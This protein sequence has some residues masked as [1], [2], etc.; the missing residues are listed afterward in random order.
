[1]TNLVIGAVAFLISILIFFVAIEVLEDQRKADELEE[2]KKQSA[3]KRAE[4]K[5][6]RA[7]ADDIMAAHAESI[8]KYKI[9]FS[10][11]EIEDVL[12]QGAYGIVCKGRYL[13]EVVAIKMITDHLF[14]DED[15]IIA[16]KDEI[17]LM[18]PLRHRNVGL[19]FSSSS[20]FL[21]LLLPI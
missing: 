15:A 3:M 16:F 2:F 14:D 20:S 19:H 13:G 18:C 1:M 7:K 11:L 12:G 21:L 5:L 10:D 6:L 9:P 4:T 17:E 8:G